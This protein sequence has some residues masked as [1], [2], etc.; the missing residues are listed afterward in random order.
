M[1]K[2]T[3][4]IE[5]GASIGRTSVIWPVL[6]VH[7]QVDT[8]MKGTKSSRLIKMKKTLRK[9]NKPKEMKGKAI[10]LLAASS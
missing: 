4:R 10:K 5:R 9:K 7:I 6:Y 2:S 3:A 8:R 1:K